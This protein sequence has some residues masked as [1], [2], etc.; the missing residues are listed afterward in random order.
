MYLKNAIQSVFWGIITAGMSLIFQLVIISLSISQTNLSEID[1]DFFGT[2]FFLFLYA[3]SEEAFKYFIVVKKI[4]PLSYG[5]SFIINAWLAGIGFSL[6]EAFIIYQKNIAEKINFSLEDVFTTAP[7]HIL[8]F[9]ILG[10]FL[11][12]SEKKKININILLFNVI[13]HFIY[14]YSILH[15]DYYSSA[16]KSAIIILLLAINVYSLLIVNKKLASD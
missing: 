11:A 13:I 16:I 4:I 7:L 10:Y 8:T 14:N 12:I 15:L 6:I 1:K 9:G 3:F 2:I 5:R